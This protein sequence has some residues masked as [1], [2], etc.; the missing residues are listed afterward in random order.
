MYPKKLALPC[1][2]VYVSNFTN[3]AQKSQFRSVIE[4]IKFTSTIKSVV[5]YI[6]R[7]YLDVK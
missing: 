4:I 5:Q 3:L 7:N 2:T 6:E 1:Y